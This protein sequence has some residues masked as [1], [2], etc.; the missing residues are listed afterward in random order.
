MSAVYANGANGLNGAGKMFPPPRYSDLPSAITISVADEEAGPLDVEIPLDE[1]IQDDPTELCD[2]LENEKSFK[3]T[4]VQVAIAYA[5]QKKLDEA[6]N[7]L[8][9]AIEVFQG[10][11][12]EDR[13][14]ILN[15]LCWLYLLKC[16]EA[17]RVK[18]GRIQLA[19]EVMM[20]NT[21][22][23]S[24]PRRQ[25]QGLLHTGGD[26]RAQRCL[27]NQPLAPAAVP[28]PW[29]PP[30]PARIATGPVNNRWHQCHKLR[31]HGDAEAGR[32]VL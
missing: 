6:V 27:P 18:S 28:R 3:S 22:R 16:R 17:P 11:R 32:Q 23:R 2:I 15:G 9:Q 25:D 30:A 1:G 31:A 12:T 19:K 14:S 26:K 10:A 21:V 13:L 29:C 7:V 20:T 24:R 4:W 8:S 5:K